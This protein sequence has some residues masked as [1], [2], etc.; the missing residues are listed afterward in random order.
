MSTFFFIGLPYASIFIMIIGIAFR[1]KFSLYNF[2]SLSSQFLE[3][4]TLHKGIRLF[5]WGIIFLFF[6]HLIGFLF[7]SSVLAW[8]RVEVRLLIIEISAFGFALSALFGLIVLI[9]R[10]LKYDRIKVVTSK[11]DVWVYIILLVQITSGLWVAYFNRWGSSWFASS[12]TPYLYSL[13][14]FSPNIAA[15]EVLPLSAQI[16]IV[17]GFLLFATIPFTRFVH[18][19]LYP[20]LYYFRNTQRVIWNW[21]PKKINLSRVI[22]KGVKPKN[23]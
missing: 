11:M 21:D 1:Y 3:A 8:N 6:G 9:I 4:N 13:F 10:R 7:P 17:S 20:I 2:S 16:H 22:N 12:L 5:H 18:F 23:N 14:T 15:I 19:L